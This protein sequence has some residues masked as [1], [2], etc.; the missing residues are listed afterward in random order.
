MAPDSSVTN[1]LTVPDGFTSSTMCVGNGCPGTMVHNAGTFTGSISGTTLTVTAITS[2]SVPVERL[3][4]ATLSGTGVTAGTQIRAQLTGS[5]G[6]TGTYTVTPS[7]TVSSTALTAISLQGYYNT[8]VGLTNFL[9]ATTANYNTGVGFEVMEFCQTCFANTAI[10]EATLIYNING[11]GNTAVGWKALLGFSGMD[12]GD[13]NTAVGYSSGWANGGAGSPTQNTSVGAFSN[14]GT[15]FAGSNNTSIGY[16][17]GNTLTTGSNNT[18]VGGAAAGGAGNGVTTGSNNTIIG[19][20]P[21]QSAGTNTTV[22]LCDGAGTV[23]FK[24]SGS[25]L[26]ATPSTPANI[27]STTGVMEG[28]GTTCHITPSYSTR[29][30]VQF[31]GSAFN[32]TATDV[33]QL[34]AAFG[35]GTAPAHNAASTGTT[36]G[37]NVDGTSTAAN[38][39]SS[40]S[41]GGII[42]GLTSGTAYWFDLQALVNAGALGINSISCTAYEL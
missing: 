41:A 13:Y 21:A 2:G 1:I 17:A 15:N 3:S 26:Q 28:F 25:T 34:Q 22:L 35:T 37:V 18:F 38:A 23:A 40:F 8:M 20:C 24:N 42:T 9:S 11:S 39:I 12:M 33:W 5:S 4:T 27:T 31:I 19:N 6:S 10:G 7:Q 36:I 14:A 16:S 32:T 29:V 30:F